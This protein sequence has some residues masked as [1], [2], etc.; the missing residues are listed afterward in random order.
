MTEV[1]IHFHFNHTL[2]NIWCRQVSRLMLTVKCDV[3]IV[4]KWS[5][6]ALQVLKILTNNINHEAGK[7]VLRT[8]KKMMQMWIIG[9]VRLVMQKKPT[10]EGRWCWD[11]KQLRMCTERA[12]LCLMLQPYV[13]IHIQ[14]VITVFGMLCLYRVCYFHIWYVIPTMVGRFSLRRLKKFDPPWAIQTWCS[15][16]FALGSWLS[17]LFLCL[18]Y[19]RVC[20]DSTKVRFWILSP[21]F[22]RKHWFVWINFTINLEWIISSLRL[23]VSFGTQVF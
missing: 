13:A 9:C 23:L 19:T 14:Y 12:L 17:T 3:L 2:L 18:R 22:H 15:V 4:A 7:P 21:S 20:Y 8:R 10:K 1:T 6:L 5:V 11:R 16:I